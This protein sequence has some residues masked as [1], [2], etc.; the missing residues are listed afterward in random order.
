[1]TAPIEDRGDV[2]RYSMFVL[3]RKRLS[4]IASRAITLHGRTPEDFAVISIHVDDPKWRPLVDKLM[5]NTPEAE[6]QRIRDQDETPIASG[7]IPQETLEILCDLL[8][9]I[10]RIRKER[11]PKGEVYALIFGDGGCSVYSVPFA[12]TVKHARV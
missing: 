10:G 12:P 5:P 6:W 4:E 1:M 8:P 11:P 3:T 7:S 2:A 9:G